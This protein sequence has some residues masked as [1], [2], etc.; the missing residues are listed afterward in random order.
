MALL[1]AGSTRVDA[2]VVLRRH[3]SLI[4]PTA[5]RRA[6]IMIWTACTTSVGCTVSAQSR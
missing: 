1:I 5:T 4:D 6:K 3:S 2:G